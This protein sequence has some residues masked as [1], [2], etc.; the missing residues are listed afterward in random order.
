M[1]TQNISYVFEKKEGRQHKKNETATVRY[2]YRSEL[3]LKW[4]LYISRWVQ[5]PLCPLK[6]IS[7]IIK[8]YT[9]EICFL[10][11]GCC[12]CCSSF[13]FFLLFCACLN[14]LDF[15]FCSLRT[16]GKKILGTRFLTCQNDNNKTKFLRTWP[17][18]STPFTL[19]SN[20]CLSIKKFGCFFLFSLYFKLS[21]L[22]SERFKVASR[23]NEKLVYRRSASLL[24]LSFACE[25]L[26][27]NGRQR[28]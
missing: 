1:N 25:I 13:S 9:T 27:K 8:T 14:W 6:H 7:H 26:L 17:L 15:L 19:N 10:L 2:K 11:F 12:C 21:S 4:D 3:N 5:V 18:F 20:N 24:F 16:E 22:L 23:K 28:S